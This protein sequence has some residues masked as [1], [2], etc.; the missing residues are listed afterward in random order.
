MKKTKTF[1]CIEMKRAAA[2][3]IYEETKEMT[4]DEEL[5][6]WRAKEQNFAARRQRSLEKMQ[7]GAGDGASSG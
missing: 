7:N 6:Y 2:L 3:R 1:D 4:I 5:A